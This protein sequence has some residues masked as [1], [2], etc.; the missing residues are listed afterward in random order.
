ML[1]G[2]LA[3]RHRER[4]VMTSAGFRK[5][6]LA[7]P[8]VEERA[9]MGHPDFRVGGRAFATMGYPRAAVRDALASAYE[10]RVLKTAKGSR[11]RK[12]R[13]N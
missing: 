6:A 13:P 7:L 10:A 11:V 9:H 3:G 8:D 2:H 12:S 5:L 1:V 4:S